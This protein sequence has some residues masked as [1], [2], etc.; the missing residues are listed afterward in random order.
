MSVS[1]ENFEVAAAPP[2]RGPK[3]ADAAL[4]TVSRFARLGLRLIFMLAAAR[5]LGP[6]HFGVYV[7]V[8]AVLEIVAVA[9]GGGFIDY[10][11]R[12]TAKD[13]RLGWRVAVQLILLRAGYAV[14]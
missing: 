13:E 10:V 4:L 12:E 3:F 8:L 1:T 2:V 14:W 6:G 7:L 5:V 11:T 9:G